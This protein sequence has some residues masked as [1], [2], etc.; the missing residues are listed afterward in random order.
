MSDYQPPSQ[1]AAP[2]SSTMGI[3]SLIAGIAGLTVFP[4]LGS[5]I[6]VITGH[7][8]KS[9]IRRSGGMITGEALA[10]WGLIL[11]YIGVGLTVL[12]LCVVGAAFA[13]LCT[14][15][16]LVPPDGSWLPGLLQWS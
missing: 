14:L 16:F 9:E 8:A 13:G 5:I 2:Q 7:M 11:G 6:A 15:P 1:P 12:G 3:I 10:T 4:V